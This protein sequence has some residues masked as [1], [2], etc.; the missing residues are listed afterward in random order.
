MYL[1]KPRLAFRPTPSLGTVLV[2]ARTATGVDG[3][4]CLK[5]DGVT[6]RRA[7]AV[8]FHVLHL[9]PGHLRVLQC[10]APSGCRRPSAKQRVVAIQTRISSESLTCDGK[11]SDWAHIPAHKLYM[12]HEGLS[13]IKYIL[14]D[15]RHKVRTHFKRQVGES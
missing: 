15:I 3:H 13:A 8:A 14:I 12:F 4:Q 7:G 5:L 9:L 2:R 6:E 11:T 1:A 10:A